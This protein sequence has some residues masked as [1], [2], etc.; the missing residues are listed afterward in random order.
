MLCAEAQPQHH[1]KKAQMQNCGCART[2]SWGPYR[3]RG[4]DLLIFV[5]PVQIRLRLNCS[6]QYGV[7]HHPVLRP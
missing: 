5:L 6:G 3:L 7:F 1:R 4:S 2:W